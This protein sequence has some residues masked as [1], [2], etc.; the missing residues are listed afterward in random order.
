M[1]ET[2]TLRIVLTSLVAALVCLA[3][4]I[5]RVPSPTGGYLNLGD[6]VAL[7]GAYLLGPAWGAVAAGLGAMLADILAGYAAYAPGTLVIKGL[8][9]LIAGALFRVFRR[10]SGRPA[11]PMLLSGLCAELWMTLG[12][13]LYTIVCLSYGPGAVAEIP[14]NLAQ[15]AAGIAVALLLT[16]ALLK[17]RELREM[18]EGLSNEQRPGR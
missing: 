10:R 9:A 13:L 7:T 12:Y 17:H 14:G 2:G 11:L 4:M 8:A 15:G 6:G 3:T 1:K 18:L 16:P 5:I